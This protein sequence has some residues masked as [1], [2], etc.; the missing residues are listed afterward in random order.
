ML[1]S[2]DFLS[3]KHKLIGIQLLTAI[4]SIVLCGIFFII[5]YYQIFKESEKEGLYSIAKVVG[6]NAIT[7]LE[8]GSAFQEN[9]AESLSELEIN[10]QITNA[11]L[12]DKEGDI[13]ASY[14]QQKD[15]PYTFE[16]IELVNDFFEKSV[17]DGVVIYYKIKNDDGF[18]GTMCLK[19]NLRTGVVLVQF[20]KISLVV[21]FM[22]AAI[23]FLLATY[24]QRS[25]SNPIVNLVES[26]HQVSQKQDYSIR[27]P[28]KG[29]DEVAEL[30]RVFNE[31]LQ[32][33]QKRD[34]SLQ[35][36]QSQLE[37]RVENRTKALQE[38]TKALELSNKELEQFAYVASH[39]L[40]EPLRMIGSFSQLIARRYQKAIDDEM[41]EYIHYIVDGVSRM[42]RLIKD[43]LTFSRVGT[44][45]IN[46]KM[47]DSSIILLKCLSNL[48]YAIEESHALISYDKMPALKIDEVRIMQLLQNLMSNAIKFRTDR[49]PKIHIGIEER[50]DE[51][52]FSVSD[53][54]IG[55]EK[56][57]ANKIFMIF[58]R[59]HN[60]SYPGTGIGLAICKKIVELHG[61]K[62]W[63]ESEKN[64]GTTFYFTIKKA[65]EEEPV[66]VEKAV[67]V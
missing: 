5:S 51:W 58:Q 34:N 45:Q 64:K 40:Q 4:F 16:S 43:L 9:A 57:Y 18:L 65:L 15:Y 27:V 46:F 3:I 61:G 62:I 47:V 23:A 30:S 11:T 56:E 20:L 44:R 25:I 29:N 17:G 21:L 28:V 10:A 6:D 13:F 48:R 32:Q 12:L 63:F 22:G 8:F 31:M 53:N 41:K 42:Q 60:T 14:N 39:D 67:A 2:N 33:I 7:E 1:N 26:M 52:M 54:G 55:I 59:L 37:A 24:F 19:A 38:K 66:V 50:A 35:E 49:V 36:A